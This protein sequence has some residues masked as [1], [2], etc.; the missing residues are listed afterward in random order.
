MV[1]VQN[2]S[3]QNVGLGKF[4]PDLKIMETFVIGLKVSLSGDFA[5]QSLRMFF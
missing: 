3:S 1:V 4:W 5:S 2:G